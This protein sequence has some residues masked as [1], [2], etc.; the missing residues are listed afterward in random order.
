MPTNNNLTFLAAK[1]VIN[2]L[3]SKIEKA[4]YSVNFFY[5]KNVS[6][7]TNLK[8]TKQTLILLLFPHP[9]LNIK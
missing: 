3:V 5:T 9:K 8:I 7:I 2:L 4:N 6:R 1:S